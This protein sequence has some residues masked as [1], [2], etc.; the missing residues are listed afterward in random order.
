MQFGTWSLGKGN[1]YSPRLI[2]LDIV[3]K[4][5][6]GLQQVR[7][8]ICRNKLC[9]NPDHL[10]FGDE[11]RFWSYVCKL[12]KKNGGCWIWIGSIQKGYGKFALLNGGK[13]KSIRAHV[14]SWYLFTGVVVSK[15]TKV[16]HKCDNPSCVN[17]H[18]LFIGT[19]QDN[20]DDKIQKG[21][22]A[23]GSS[24]NTCKLDDTKVKEIR[25]LFA[26]GD[27]T[28][29]KL[30]TLYGVSDA[31]IGCILRGETWKHVA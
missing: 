23:K 25:D 13:K 31:N 20:V 15:S 12:S 4:S 9:V 21:R 27:Y 10:V 26:T 16:C 29:I 6:N 1:T 7:P 19:D 30:G 24:I 14:Y 2:S 8:L 5:P 3:G 11:G 28:K 18:H 17:P 22:Q